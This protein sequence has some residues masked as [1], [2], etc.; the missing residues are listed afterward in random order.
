MQAGREPQQI[1]VRRP[2]PRVIV[3]THVGIDRHSSMNNAPCLAAG[4]FVYLSKEVH[5]V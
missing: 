1:D 4:A 2:V 3:G 5:H